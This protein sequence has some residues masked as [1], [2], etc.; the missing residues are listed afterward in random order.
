MSENPED[1]HPGHDTEGGEGPSGHLETDEQRAD[2]DPKAA[3]PKPGGG[4]GAAGAGG[5]SPERT[6]RRRPYSP[7]GYA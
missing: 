5:P 2:V 1:W 7:G 4:G 6:S 3:E